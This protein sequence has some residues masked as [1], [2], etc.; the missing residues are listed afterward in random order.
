MKELKG[1]SASSG[2]TIGRAFRVKEVTGSEAMNI[3]N[4]FQIDSEI[5]LLSSASVSVK[6]R[7]S[8]YA[9]ENEI[10]GAQIEM[11]EDI[12]Q[13]V[14]STIKDDKI[15]AKSAVD[16]SCKEIC[17][18]FADIDDEYLRSRSDDVVDVCRQIT[19][20]L[21]KNNENPF[22]GMSQNSIIIADNLLA[23]DTTLIDF[24]NL[25]GIILKRGSTTSHLAI[26]AKNNGIPLILGVGDELDSIR[27]EDIISIDCERGLI[28]TGL[29]EKELI[30]GS[31][32]NKCKDD[33]D[34]F[35]AIT[36]DGTGI[37]VYANAGSIIDVKKAIE[38]GADGIGLLRTE[39]LFMQGK[40]FPSEDEQYNIYS[41]C[42]RI[43]EGKVLTI[44][45]LDIGAD[46]QLPY[47]TMG[48]EENPV[49]GLRGIRFS[50]ASPDIF[51]VQLR[52]ILR[53]SLSGNVRIM[54]PMIASMQEYMQACTLFNTCKTELEREG[55]GFD[56][57][58][59]V[60]MMIETPASV[61]LADDFAQEAAFFSI[62]TND[63]TQYTLAVDRNNPYSGDACDSHHPAIFKS[64]S[65]VIHSAK[66][67]GTDVSICG[68][69][70]SDPKAVGLLLK[71][72]VRKL[73]VSSHS[74]SSVKKQIRE[75]LIN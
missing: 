4:D 22:S 6:E 15:D 21:D 69:L 48:Y 29:H 62:G 54:F 36:K 17:A 47:F 12:T 52:A 24:S 44:R 20:V 74:I 56:P 43:C 73:S 59:Q 51:K 23:S 64:I 11:L 26:L 58:M 10:F 46:K 41:E 19:L 68:E 65:N 34:L 3:I 1:I 25:T 66:K 32:E 13:R 30:A 45:T 71:L 7:L 60:G 75:L 61:L 38:R 70:A 50:L 14:I 55:L 67:N 28:V 31:Q 35:P 5:H 2:K 27:N 37:T 53:A 63:L 8:P 72:G 9:Q 39:F 49:L 57:S 40:D 18:M 16:K 42:A 33:V